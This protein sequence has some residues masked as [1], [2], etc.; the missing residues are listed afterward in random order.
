MPVCTNH[1]LH[2][3]CYQPDY[4]LCKDGWSGDNC[5]QPL[6]SHVCVHGQCSSPDYC[7]CFGGW[8]GD[9]CSQPVCMEHCDFTNGYC[10]QPGV[11]LCK[12][13]WDGV[14]CNVSKDNAETE[15]IHYQL[16]LNSNFITLTPTLLFSSKL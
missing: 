14:Y 15:S 9:N 10:I 11:C 12:Y 13:S 8:F 3:Y 7:T 16:T 6:C 4:C 2:G 1:C 5:S